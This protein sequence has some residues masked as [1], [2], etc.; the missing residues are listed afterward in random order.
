MNLAYSKRQLSAAGVSFDVGLTSDEFSAV[1]LAYGF[2]FPPDLR[3]F[4]GFALPV[5]KG[6]IDWRRES[7]SEILARL[8]WPYE[9]M[10][11]DIEH[12]TF[13]L[14][15]WGSKPSSLRRR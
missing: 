2:K 14:E 7:R 8:D 13:W 9:G 10:C 6:W 5:S 1:E 4:L 11:F 15:S 12:N 3:E